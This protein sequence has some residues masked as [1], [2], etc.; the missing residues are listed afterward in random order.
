[1]QTIETVSEPYVVAK[2]L[3]AEYFSP[4]FSEPI[5]KYMRD[6]GLSD[7][8]ILSPNVNNSTDNDVRARILNAARGYLD[9]QRGS[10]FDG[11]PNDVEWMR[12]RYP[13]SELGGVLLSTYPEWQVITRNTRLLSE[14]ADYLMSTDP[15]GNPARFVRD[16]VFSFNP[17]VE[18]PPIVLLTDENSSRYVLLEGAVRSISHWLLRDRV[19]VVNGIIG[20]SAHMK[21]W[22]DF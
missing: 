5:H 10:I 19:T 22:H 18:Y 11:F 9:R 4:R 14:A 21:Q 1:M 2:F 15:Q 8:I 12:V 7:Q 17:E 13:T 3:E 6:H 16:F 20:R